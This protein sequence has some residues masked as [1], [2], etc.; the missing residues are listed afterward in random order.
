MLALIALG[1]GDAAARL[2]VLLADR[3]LDL[4]VTDEGRSLAQCA[5]AE[6]FEHLAVMI[7]REVRG[8][9]GA[10]SRVVCAWAWACACELFGLSKFCGVVA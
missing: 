1:H 2:G 7:D 8:G 4:S 9:P 3:R 10:V 5:A 6:G